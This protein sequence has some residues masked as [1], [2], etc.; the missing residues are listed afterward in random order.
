MQDVNLKKVEK[1]SDHS[2]KGEKPKYKYPKQ[3]DDEL[4]IKFK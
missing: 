3:T 2:V 4:T 1:Q